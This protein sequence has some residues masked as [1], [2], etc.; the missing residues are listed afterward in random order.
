MKINYILISGLLFLIISC[1]KSEKEIEQEKKQ[2][3]IEQKALAKKKEQQRVHLEKIEVG[4]SILK[5]KLSK[6]L[7]QLK[8]VLLE[9]EN[10]LIEINKFQLGRTNSTKV[11]ELN[12]QNLK[13]GQIKSYISKIEK[14]ISLT[15]LRETF[16]FQDKPEGVIKFLFDSAKNKAFGKLRYLCDPYGE[17][18]GDSKGI[19][20]IEM[21]PVEM[22]N[23]FV[24]SF[25]NGRIIGEPKIENDK[26]VIEIAFGQNS[27]RLEKINLVRRMNK[28]YIVSL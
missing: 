17:N 12:K 28:W 23:Q 1:G 25:K 15:N 14:E 16:D 24:K 9:Q 21:Q 19:C 26:A 8:K 7:D 22:Q 11:N 6:E 27:D 4:K 5:T 3:E 20:F 13:I 2:V 18:D 10:K